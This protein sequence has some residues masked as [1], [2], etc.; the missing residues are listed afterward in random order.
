[1]KLSILD[2]SPV[3]E[4]LTPAEALGHTIALAGRADAL[5]YERYWIA[6]HHGMAG[7]AST[8]PEILIARLGAETSTIRIGSGAVLLPHYSPMKVAETFRG[9]AAVVRAARRGL[10]VSAAGL[11]ATHRKGS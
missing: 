9:A 3:P 10:W 4:G 8:A 11:I 6:E 5:G 2:Q 7:L 1:L